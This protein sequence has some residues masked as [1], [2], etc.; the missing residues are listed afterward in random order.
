MAQQQNEAGLSR[1]ASDALST[2][3]KW[4]QGKARPAL[5]IPRWWAHVMTWPQIEGL[6]K[7]RPRWGDVD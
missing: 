2:H 5:G 1:A 7:G 6:H 4:G 3:W